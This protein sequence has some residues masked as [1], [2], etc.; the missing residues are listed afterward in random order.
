[1]RLRTLPLSLS[2]VSLG[3]MLAAADYRVGWG[4]AVW[5]LLTTVCLQILSNICNELGDTL[6]GVDRAERKGPKYSLAEGGMTVREMKWFIAATVICCIACGLCMIRSSFGTLLALEPVC[7]MMLGAAAISG[8]MKY[9]LGRNPYGYRGLGDVYVFLFFG[10]VAVLGSYFVAARTIPSWILLLPA[11]GI[12]MLSIGVLNVNNMRDMNSDEGIRITIP[13][14][15]GL[16]NARI[17][18]TILVCGGIVCIT[19]YSLL[20]FPDPWHYLYLVTLPLFVIHLRGIWTRQDEA[21]D[22]M[23]PLL[24]I[25]TFALSLLA[26]A[27][28]LVFLLGNA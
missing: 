9:T 24:V 21:L 6:N 3:L 15:I 12:G 20:R 18:Q 27:G 5:T 7:L 23:L 22:P 17:Y 2:G 16:R 8:A 14:R 26:G 28:Y 11:C 13:L 4:T 1:M 25:S 19:V 10:I